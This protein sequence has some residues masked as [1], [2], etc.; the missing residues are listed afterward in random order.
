MNNPTPA[1]SYLHLSRGLVD[2]V[3]AQLPQIQQAADWFA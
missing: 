1:Q 2:K 3:E